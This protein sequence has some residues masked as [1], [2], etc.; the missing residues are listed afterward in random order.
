MCE[1]VFT[2]ILLISAEI[3]L[4]PLLLLLIVSRMFGAED[5]VIGKETIKESIRFTLRLEATINKR[6]KK[7]FSAF[8]QFSA[9]NKWLWFC[10]IAHLKLTAS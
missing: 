2:L 9:H 5:G 6:K 7:F 1:D 8:I 10:K 4:V 3:K